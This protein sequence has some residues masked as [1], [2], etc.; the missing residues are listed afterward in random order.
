MHQDIQ[1]MSNSLL[2]VHKSFD[3]QKGKYQN[4]LLRSQTPYR[5]ANKTRILPGIRTRNLLITTLLQM[6]LEPTAFCSEDR[7]SAIEPL[8]LIPRQKLHIYKP[9]LL[10][11]ILIPQTY[12]HLGPESQQIKFPS[13]A[14]YTKQIKRQMFPTVQKSSVQVQ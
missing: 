7:C 1:S 2:M 13:S 4:N 9:Q 10:T 12:F 5:W 6:G 8:K 14:N 3:F 11:I